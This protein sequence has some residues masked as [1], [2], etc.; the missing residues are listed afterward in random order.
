[1]SAHDDYVDVLR[2]QLGIKSWIPAWRPGADIRLGAVGRI[3]DGEFVRA[4]DL[5]DR[6]LDRDLLTPD[7]PDKD[8]D[9]Y[10]GSSHNAVSVDIKASGKSDAAFQ[11][12]GKASIGVK[13]SFSRESAVA[14][15]YRD[16]VEQRYT[17]ERSIGDA[18]VE[19]WSGGP[20]PKMKL[21]DFAIT[22]IMVAG[23]G[24]VFGAKSSNTS[25]LME[26]SANAKIPDG[27]DLGQLKG[28]FAIVSEH[29]TEFRAYSPGGRR[30]V[31]IGYRGLLLT[32]EGWFVVHTVA[33]P[34]WQALML[35]NE[36]AAVGDPAAAAGIEE[37]FP[38]NESAVVD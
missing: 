10:H 5:E 16:V 30:G 15:V 3:E 7:E 27:A 22:Q 21:G 12:V 34:K 26:F 14:M 38:I 36:L 13:L 20:L 18:M 17:D 6:G 31:V 24:F 32:Q 19:S 35:A 28:R 8:P 33:K 25:V 2:D 29:E 9:D 23:W 37:A 1:M 11:G 4:Y